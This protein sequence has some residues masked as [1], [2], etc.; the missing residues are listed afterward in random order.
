MKIT[1][2]KTTHDG[3]DAHRVVMCCGVSTLGINAVVMVKVRAKTMR[4]V[5]NRVD[6]VGMIVGKITYVGVG[7]HVMKV[8]WINAVVIVRCGNKNNR[9]EG[10]ESEVGMI[11]SNVVNVVVLMQPFLGGRGAHVPVPWYPFT[12]KGIYLQAVLPR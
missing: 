9:I 8:R 11:V 10:R 12:A 7:V 6:E 5:K 2:D 4:S 1:N 3:S